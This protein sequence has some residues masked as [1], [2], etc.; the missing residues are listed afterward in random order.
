ME[1]LEKS[2]LNWIKHEGEYSRSILDSI[3][4]RA[5]L[6]KQMEAFD[7]SFAL[8]DGYQKY[9]NRSFFR[10]RDI[11][12][13]DFDL[14]VRDRTGTRKVVD[15]SAIRA[16]SGGVPLA[17]NYFLASP[18]GSKIAVG[19]SR[20]GSE[21]AKLRVYD[22][23]TGKGIGGSV[24]RA[25]FGMMAWSDDSSTLY[26]NRLKALSTGESTQNRYTGST[27]DAW[28]LGSSP[29]T[30]VGHAALKAAGL[31]E[32]ETPQIVISSTSSMAALRL[33]NG[34]D[35][36]I[37]IWLKPKSKIEAPGSWTQ[38]VSHHDGVTAFTLSRSSIYFL[39]NAKAPT[40][41]VLALKVGLPFAQVQ[42]VLPANPDRIIDSIHAAED[43][44]YVVA[45]RGIYASLLR[46]RPNG[47]VDEIALPDKG[48]IDEHFLIPVSQA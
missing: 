13:D 12:A 27:V 48:K 37:A 42:T 36:N 40:F 4:T 38:L 1:L 41:K 17:I 47:V 21:N 30:A 7:S 46:L 22:V 43:G 2:T 20:E 15:I 31:P 26:F 3:P 8:A 34:A 29:F 10:L 14:M 16:A 19:I 24:D 44:L 6:E 23:A 18:D 45:R 25:Q 5:R 33:E 11:E 28:K 32:S 9:G 35:P 39:S